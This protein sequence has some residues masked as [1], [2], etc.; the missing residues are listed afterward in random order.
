MLLLFSCK[1]ENGDKSGERKENL[2]DEMN[3]MFQSR[4][5]ETNKS[6]VETDCSLGS[7]IPRNDTSEIKNCFPRQSG[8][9]KEPQMTG[10]G[11]L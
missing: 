9:S 2:T 6:Q 7:N 10:V 4:E 1:R 5:A 3:D 8:I 11:L